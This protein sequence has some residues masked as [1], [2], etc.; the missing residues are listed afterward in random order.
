MLHK[1]TKE[2]YD[3]P[4]PIKPLYLALFA[5]F[6]HQSM[7]QVIQGTLMHFVFYAKITIFTST[8]MDLKYHIFVPILALEFFTACILAKK[9][10]KQ[11][12]QYGTNRI[13]WLL[14]CNLHG[15]LKLFY[16]KN[17]LKYIHNFDADQ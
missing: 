9:L 11:L 10:K 16:I 6:G 3:L 8:F 12:S 4:M 5:N 1:I 7:H 13:M 15:M 17:E 2:K 14:E